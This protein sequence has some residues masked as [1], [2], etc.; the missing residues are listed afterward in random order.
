ML[1]GQKYTVRL[2]FKSNARLK[3]LPSPKQVHKDIL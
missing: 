1:T 3:N 2:H